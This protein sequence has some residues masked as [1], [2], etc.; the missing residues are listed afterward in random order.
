M[1]YDNT[2]YDPDID[3]AQYCEQALTLFERFKSCYNSDHVDSV[4]QLL[5]EIPGYEK[6]VP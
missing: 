6:N 5:L 1:F 4:V 3:A 2:E